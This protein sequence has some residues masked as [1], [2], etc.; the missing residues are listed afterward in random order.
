MHDPIALSL[1]IACGIDALDFL[2]TLLVL[3]GLLMPAGPDAGA[4]LQGSDD[5]D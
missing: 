2:A 3:G 4:P 1:W 5:V